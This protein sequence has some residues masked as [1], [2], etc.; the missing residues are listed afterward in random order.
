MTMTQVR[1]PS[2]SSPGGLDS[3]AENHQTQPM[4]GCS[5]PVKY[6][7]DVQQETFNGPKKPLMPR[8]QAARY[9]PP[10]SL[11]ASQANTKQRALE[12]EFAFLQ[13]IHTKSKCPEY[14][15][16]NTRYC[17]H[18]GML[19]RPHTNVAFLP[20]IERSPAHPDTI[21]TRSTCVLIL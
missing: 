5:K 6:D 9:V 18:A 4:Q 10:L 16:Y 17:R 1:P 15:G 11:L 19:P 21:K 12:N 13:D 14:N 7:H 8:E 2:I 20:L 3:H